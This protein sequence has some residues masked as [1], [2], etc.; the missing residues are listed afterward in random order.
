MM[1]N[2]ISFDINWVK[3]FQSK[4]YESLAQKKSERQ[5]WAIGSCNRYARFL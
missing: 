1:K 5:E 2:I 4:A 3:I